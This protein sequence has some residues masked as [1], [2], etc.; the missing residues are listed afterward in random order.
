MLFPRISQVCIDFDGSDPS[1]LTSQNDTSSEAIVNDGT[2]SWMDS[3]AKLSSFGVLFVTDLCVP[4]LYTPF[5]S[6][7]PHVSNMEP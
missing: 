4:E 2:R 3:V 1:D 6:K 5:P 7:S